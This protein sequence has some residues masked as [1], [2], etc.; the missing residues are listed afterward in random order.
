LSTYFAYCRRQTALFCGPGGTGKIMK[1][2]ILASELYLDVC[3]I[4][5]SSVVS[6]YVGE[7]EGNLLLVFDAVVDGGAILFLMK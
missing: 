7:T 4:D 5:L 1:V 2:E 3:R 6:K